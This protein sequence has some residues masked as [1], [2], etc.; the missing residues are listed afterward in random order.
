MRFDVEFD[1]ESVTLQG[2]LYRPEGRS[3]SPAVAMFHG[4]SAVKERS[5]D[6]FA[7]EIVQAGITVLLLDYRDFGASDGQPRQKLDP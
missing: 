4:L 7:E 1:A 6:L 3:A 2:W 5:L